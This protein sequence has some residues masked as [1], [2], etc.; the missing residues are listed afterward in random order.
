ML[1]LRLRIY[2]LEIDTKEELLGYTVEIT[3]AITQATIDQ[4]RASLISY[5]DWLLTGA[6][7]FLT[8]KVPIFRTLEFDQFDIAKQADQILDALKELGW[9]AQ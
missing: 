8:M 2:S 1:I 7:A 6:T 4:D 9:Y 3:N 5:I